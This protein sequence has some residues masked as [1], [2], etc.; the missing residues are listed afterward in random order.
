MGSEDI[1]YRRA[2]VSLANEFRKEMASK[3]GRF[4]SLKE[5]PIGNFSPPSQILFMHSNLP[6][7]ELI[8]LFHLEEENDLDFHYYSSRNYKEMMETIEAGVL[9]DPWCKIVGSEKVG[10][11]LA[12]IIS[13]S[14]QYNILT[15]PSKNSILLGRSEAETNFSVQL[16]YGTILGADSIELVKKIGGPAIIEE[17]AQD[18]DNQPSRDTTILDGF[19]AH[20]D[21]PVWIDTHEER[22]FI[23]KVYRYPSWKSAKI[24][25]IEQDFGGYIALICKD[26]YI[27][28]GTKDKE[29]ALSAINT[30]LGSMMV[31]L[32][33]PFNTVR[34]NDVGSATFSMTSSSLSGGKFWAHSEDYDTPITID[35]DKVKEF[36]VV[37]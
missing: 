3:Y 20:A 27:A 9:R 16:L 24:I 8:L 2:I 30:L 11:S 1:K 31:I 4:P 35:A 12:N 14:K 7:I 26:G 5:L 17:H 13:N 25:H 32:G 18:S 19:G 23:D 28:I 33:I 22:H 10:S 37:S 36:L 21:P 6:E 34:E 29:E 15:V